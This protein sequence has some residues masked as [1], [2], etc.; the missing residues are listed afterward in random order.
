M[1]LLFTWVAV[2]L[3]TCRAYEAQFDA[4]CVEHG[5]DYATPKERATRLTVFV[6]NATFVEAHNA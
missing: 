1:P 5:W 2:A 6:D 4:W 3:L